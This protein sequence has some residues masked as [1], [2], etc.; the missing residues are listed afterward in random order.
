MFSQTET[1][2]FV[3]N[4][5]IDIV[6]GCGGVTFTSLIHQGS[7]RSQLER[8]PE[9]PRGGEGPNP[10]ASNHPSISS[11]FAHSFAHPFV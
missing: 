4:L 1:F 10:K 8:L 7:R 6:I 5:D 11:P 2:C 3:A 9:G